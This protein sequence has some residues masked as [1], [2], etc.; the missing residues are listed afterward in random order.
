MRFALHIT[1]EFEVWLLICILQLVTNLIKLFRA[2]TCTY[3]AKFC[4]IM[5]LKLGRHNSYC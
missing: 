3:Y 2:R 1:K 5:S 4:I